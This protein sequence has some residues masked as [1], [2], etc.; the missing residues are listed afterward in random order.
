LDFIHSIEIFIYHPGILNVFPIKFTINQE[1]SIINQPI[2]TA[3]QID[4][5]LSIASGEPKEK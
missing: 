1:K 3:F 2:P 5:A 4:F